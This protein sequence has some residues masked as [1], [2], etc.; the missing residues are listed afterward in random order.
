[1]F[2]KRTTEHLCRN[3]CLDRVCRLYLVGKVGREVA[4]GGVVDVTGEPHVSMAKEDHVRSSAGDEEVRAHVKLSSIQKQ[5]TLDVT[6][7]K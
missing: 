2:K 1:M 5:W 7:E 6:E 4:G 3:I